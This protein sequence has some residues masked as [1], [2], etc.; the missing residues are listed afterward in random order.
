MP[1]KPLS[2]QIAELLQRRRR[3]GEKYK[4]IATRA[5]VHPTQISRLVNREG[6]VSLDVLDRLGIYLGLEIV[7]YRPDPESAKERENADRTIEVAAYLDW[8]KKEEKDHAERVWSE[9][10]RRLMDT[11]LEGNPS[12]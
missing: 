10:K 5:G 6:G 3:S 4:E 12:K 7:E 8:L 11:E 2:E 1:P 9:A